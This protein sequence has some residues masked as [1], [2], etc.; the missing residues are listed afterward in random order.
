MHPNHRDTPPLPQGD[1]HLAP[2]VRNSR[3]RDTNSAARE[4]DKDSPRP[5]A[6][7]RGITNLLPSRSLQDSIW[8]RSLMLAHRFRV[9]RTIDIAVNCFAERPF[10]AALSA[11]Q[12]AVRGMVKAK[13]LKRYRTDR[14]MTVYGLTQG[15]ADWLATHDIEASASVRRVGDMS[16]PEHRL[17]AQF[18]TLCSEA[19]G[20]PAMTEQELLRALELRRSSS[21][22]PVRGLLTV[23]EHSLGRRNRT[24]HL[25]PDAVCFE[26]DGLTW[27]EVDRSARGSGRASSLRALVLR[28]GEM[29][30]AGVPLRRVVVYTRT[31]RI[32][33][34]VLATL[35]SICVQTSGDAL[36]EG[37]RQLKSLTPA[38]FETWRTV[39]QPQEGGRSRLVDILCGEVMVQALPVWLPRVRMDGRGDITTQGWLHENYLPYVRLT[40]MA[41]WPTLRSPLLPPDA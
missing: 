33:N 4:A 18:L 15:G 35:R 9:I 25:R 34:R 11:A 30:H 31:E 19:R 38:R 40:P 41:Y 20:L 14:F 27:L 23:T 3:H 28:I 36:V 5:A 8:C 1:S 26:D 39:L 21:D 7:T 22:A 37:R 13:L 10:K 16:N 32:R 12:R 6:V 17:W 24:L 29:T 2:K